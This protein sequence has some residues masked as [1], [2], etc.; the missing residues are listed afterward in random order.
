MTPEQDN[1]FESRL[2]WII[3]EYERVGR[4]VAEDGVWPC[5]VGAVLLAELCDRAG[6]ERE[7]VTGLYW[8]PTLKDYAAATGEDFDSLVESAKPGTN[9]NEPRE[10]LHTW[11]VARSE[12]GTAFLLDPNG[13]VRNEPR[14]QPL[15]T[16]ARYEPLDEGHESVELPRHI[17]AAELIAENWD[18]RLTRALAI[19]KS[20]P[21]P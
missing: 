15:E 13:E 3:D 10:E 8:H 1:A 20:P 16:A 18:P 17:T 6:I 4:A 21:R 12:L 14:V 9:P 2:A 11:V 7:V 19:L 5:D